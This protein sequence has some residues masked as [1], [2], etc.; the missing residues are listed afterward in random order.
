M[1]GRVAAAVLAACGL[2]LLAPGSA[3]AM[4][5]TVTHFTDQ[6]S[7]TIDCGTF[8]D[9]FIDY[10]TI[11]ETTFYDEQ[12]NVARV[13]DEVVHTSD[14]VNSVTGL[15]LHEHGHATLTFY[16][17]TGELD[18][19]G[20]LF[21]MTRPTYGIVVLAV[22]RVVLDA[23]GNVVQISGHFQAEDQDYCNGLS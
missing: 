1:A 14:D 2:I 13:V 8:S 4:S 21:V 6:G 5:P 16:P 17:A 23:E 19:D 18:I 7:G 20:L 22:G 12:G 15:T 10:F 11:T 3:S 9:N